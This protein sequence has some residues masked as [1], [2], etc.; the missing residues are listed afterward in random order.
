MFPRHKISQTMFWI[1]LLALQVYGQGTCCLPSQPC[2][3]LDDIQHQCGSDYNSAF[4]IQLSG[5]NITSLTP[6]A[7]FE[8]IAHLSLDT[9]NLLSLHEL[10]S[11]VTILDLQLLNNPYLTTGSTT[12]ALPI[13]GQLIIQNNTHLRDIKTLFAPVLMSPA[14]VILV[15]N[16][17]L[18]S[19][20]GLENVS[21]TEFLQIENNPSLTSLIGLPTTLTCQTIR[22]VANRALVKLGPAKWTGNELKLWHNPNLSTLMDL[23]LSTD[24]TRLFIAQ[25]NLQKDAIPRTFFA[26]G[27]TAQWT[28]FEIIEPKL[29]CPDWLFYSRAQVNWNA[30]NCLD[31]FELTQ[32][33]PTSGPLSGGLNLTLTYTGAIRVPSVEL[34]FGKII[35][36]DVGDGII[37]V[38]LP[39]S[40]HTQILNV[41]LKLPQS[42]YT[43]SYP[44]FAYRDDAD[45]YGFDIPTSTISSVI[46]PGIP[47]VY[48]DMSD[49][50]NSLSLTVAG[51]GVA[52]ILVCL[53][54]YLML[55]RCDY[56]VLDWQR[57]DYL[58]PIHFNSGRD[59]RIKLQ[60]HRSHLG[61]AFTILTIA[62]VIIALAAFLTMACVSYYDSTIALVPTA[63]LYAPITTTFTSN[64]TFVGGEDFLCPKCSLNVSGFSTPSGTKTECFHQIS[65]CTLLWSCPGCSLS[66]STANLGIQ[67]ESNG[68][69]VQIYWAITTLSHAGN[70]TVQGYLQAEPNQFFRGDKSQINLLAVRERYTYRGDIPQ[71]GVIMQVES[72]IRG[73]QL[74]ASSFSQQTGFGLNVDIGVNPALLQIS[75][76]V[77]ESLI[78][79]LAQTFSLVLGIVGVSKFLLMQI[80]RVQSRY[81]PNLEL[82][83]SLL[84]NVALL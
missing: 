48:P 41:T 66:R 56:C 10:N 60:S 53:V 29:C 51:V 63:N 27:R 9:T 31:C 73:Q 70:S 74:N 35:R 33:Q 13:G 4:N 81:Q 83:Q 25:N 71:D 72:I 1:F 34:D 58:H 14:R 32:V 67:S 76:T 55:H 52:L 80:Q 75:V 43:T 77:R 44:N 54:V 28:L 15:N 61:G 23:E 40:Q 57:W 30:F 82:Q 6:L 20:I 62:G 45:F 18:S 49:R 36:A 2:L 3:S 7:K 79:L 26:L 64:F 19:L 8:Q 50:A 21:P 65:K 39:A 16:P 17:I 22:L 37:T 59:G 69:A 42:N 78:S 68:W 47:G 5:P 12:V 11:H 84:S 38:I 24:Y 46:Q